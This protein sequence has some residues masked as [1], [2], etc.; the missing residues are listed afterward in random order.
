MEHTE[1]MQAVVDQ[2]V[3]KMDAARA[4]ENEFDDLPDLTM[5]QIIEAKDRVIKR[6]AVPEWGGA[7]YVR[8]MSSG[9]KERYIKSVRRKIVSGANITEEVVLEESSARLAQMTICN[10]AGE[11]MFNQAQIKVLT[12]KSAKAMQRVVDAAAELNGLDEAAEN[13]AKNVLAH[14]T[15]NDDSSTD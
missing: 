1:D 4:S 12:G 6:V 8:S 10:K 14:L 7:I 11:L 3:A 13:E 2:Q 15:A 9:E 5:Q